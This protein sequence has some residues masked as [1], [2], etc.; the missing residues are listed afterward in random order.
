MPASYIPAKIT[1]VQSYLTVALGR[2]T[3]PSQ[4]AEKRSGYH[5]RRP[6]ARSRGKGSVNG[7]KKMATKK[8]IVWREEPLGTSSQ[9]VEVILNSDW[10]QKF[11]VFFCPIRGQQAVQSFRVFLHGNHLIAI[12]AWFI[13]QGFAR[14]EKSQSQH[15]MYRKSLGI[16]AEKYAEPF[17]GIFTVAYFQVCG[18]CLR[19]SSPIH[20]LKTAVVYFDLTI[21]F[22]L[23][24]FPGRGIGRG[25]SRFLT[26]IAVAQ[27]LLISRNS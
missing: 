4:K 16:S 9:T 27:T 14:G 1:V 23:P 25:I 26:R 24:P 21:I 20:L 15:K 22:I 19:M 18:I 13:W 8:S 3:N 5:P 2:E 11:F 17:A 12:L 10:C 6:R 7:R